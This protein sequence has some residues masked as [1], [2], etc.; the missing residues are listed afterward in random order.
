MGQYINPSEGKEEFLFEHGTL[1]Q[2]QDFMEASFDGLL[3]KGLM[4]VI[5]MDSGLF[6]AAAICFCDEQYEH[7]KEL[8]KSDQR[9]KLFYTVPKDKL[10]KWLPKND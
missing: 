1:I 5:W 7:F 8:A 2:P 3:E 9:P 4:A 10:K 6:T